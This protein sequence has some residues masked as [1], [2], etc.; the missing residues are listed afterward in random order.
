MKLVAE[1]TLKEIAEMIG[2]EAV[3]DPDHKV[4]GLNEIHVVEHGDLVF[5]DHPKYYTK[6][7]ESAATTILINKVVDCPEG[8]ALLISDDPF[9]DYNKL[10]RKFKPFQAL[11]S[12]ISETSSIGEGTVIQPNVTVGNNVSIG[13][14]CIIYSGVVL[15]DNTI[16]EDN[17]VIHSNTVIGADAFYYKKRPE[18]YDKMHSCGRVIIKNGA[19]IGG[20]C[21][22]DRGVS[23]DTIIGEGTKLDNQIQ[24]GHDTVIGKNCLFAANVGVAGC[25]TIEDNVTLWGQVGVISDITIHEGAVV[26]AQSGVGK[27]LNAR[28]TYFGSPCDSARIKYREMAA[29]KQLPGIIEKL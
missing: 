12:P 24:I 17:V 10:T 14:D 18:G 29:I 5:V 16:I 22:I 19:E 13:K 2:C 28:T 9:R 11:A 3:G 27:S 26:L 8:K 21:T 7:L 1:K 25:V 4:T 6:A 20:L 23:G 15:Y